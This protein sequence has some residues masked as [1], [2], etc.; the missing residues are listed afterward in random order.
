MSEKKYSDDMPYP[1]GHELDGVS[2]PMPS[3]SGKTITDAEKKRRADAERYYHEYMA[4]DPKR[5]RDGG[6]EHMIRGI[7]FALRRDREERDPLAER[8]EECRKRWSNAWWLSWDKNGWRVVHYDKLPPG[9]GSG[10]TP[11]QAVDAA[12]EGE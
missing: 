5:F 6:V 10:A 7:A 2:K 4:T 8:L 3:D 11:E 9:R 12:L 1:P